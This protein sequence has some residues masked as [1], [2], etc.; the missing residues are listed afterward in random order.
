MSVFWRL[1]LTAFYVVHVLGWSNGPWDAYIQAPTSRTLRSTSIHSADGSIKSP[2]TTGALFTTRNSTIVLDFGKQVAGLISVSFGARTFSNAALGVGFSESSQF[3]AALGSDLSQDMSNPDLYIT[4]TPPAGVNSTLTAPEKNLRGGFRYLS[5]C[6]LADAVLDVVDVSLAYT[7]APQVVDD[8][9]LGDYNGYFYSA[10][11]D[12]LNRIFYAGAHTIQ[13]TTIGAHQG[14]VY[15]PVFSGS[16]GWDDSGLL[17]PLSADQA[18]IVDGAKRDRSAWPGDLGVALESAFVTGNVGAMD[19]VK[20]NL[21]TLW[22]FQDSQT[23]ELPWVSPPIYSSAN[24]NWYISD[25]YS[26]WAIVATR[27]Y[28]AYSGD[29]AWISTIWSQY[30]LSI[31]WVLSKVDSTGLYFSTHTGDWGRVANGGHSLSANVLAFRSLQGAIQLSTLLGKNTDSIPGW[32]STAQGLRTAVNDALWDDVQGMYRD[33]DGS[34]LYPQDGNT[35]AVLFDIAD[36]TQAARISTGLTGNWNEF[37]AIAPEASGTISPFV[38][39]FEVKAHF[40]AGNSSAAVEIIRRMWGYAL[41]KF[42]NSTVIEG[43]FQDGSLHYP[44]YNGANSYISHTHGWSTGPS[45]SLVFNLVG[46]STDV[47]LSTPNT[48]SVLDGAWIFSPATD[49][50]SAQG[51]FRTALGEFSA[52]WTFAD[53]PMLTF[54]ATLNTPASAAGKIAIP[55]EWQATVTVD[56]VVVYDAVNGPQGGVELNEG[57]VWVAVGGGTHTVEATG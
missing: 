19:A 46:M 10:N 45:A 51:G 16:S 13:L 28:W 21:I 29:T 2:T 12:L 54:K 24:P 18:V 14:R 7:P 39:S 53:E 17:P 33:N 48:H 15:P 57:R 42:S 43:Y 35:I 38:T 37:G 11:D 9:S 55:V 32:N 56:G 20:N 5:L 34:T 50:P 31:D 52:Q 47:S 36:P 3:I 1:F 27:D 44:S 49:V 22:N 30:L 25:V 6:A 23:G 8:S 26:M 40:K 41:N 4:F